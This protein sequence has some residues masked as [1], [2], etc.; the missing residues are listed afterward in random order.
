MNFVFRVDASDSIGSGHVMRCLSLA[1]ELEKR[2]NSIRFI[3]CN[4]D[5]NL[6]A[7]I[8]RKGYEVHEIPS[9]KLPLVDSH[10]SEESR[11]IEINN[12]ALLTKK[13]IENTKVDWLI[14]DHY[15]LDYKWELKLKKHVEAVLVIDD[16][17][18]RKHDCNILLDQNWFGLETGNRYAQLINKECVTL[19]GPNFAILSKDYINARK[20]LKEHS[21]VI[22]RILI[23]MGAVD[24]KRQTI[25]ALQALCNED[26]RYLSVDVVIGGAN[27]DKNQIINITSSRKKTVIYNSLPTLSELMM[28]ADLILCSGGATTWE[29]CC[30]GLPAIVFIAAENQ[31]KFTKLLAKDNVHVLLE[32][33]NEIT[34]KD[35]FLRISR[36][37]KNTNKVKKM[38]QLSSQ[39]VDGRG[40]SRI[41]LNLY[42]FSMPIDI[43]KATEDD[44]K[45]LF[46]W[47][48]DPIVRKFSFHH[49]P[50]TND[51]HHK[52][53]S[54][55][56][57]D[58]DCL[59]L[60]GIDSKNIP[61]GQVR[62]DS[63]DEHDIIDISINSAARGFGFATILLKKS[64]KFWKS[65]GSN[66]PL[67][68]DVFK[69]NKASQKVFINS[70]FR[71]KDNDN[72]NANSNGVIRYILD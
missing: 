35:W 47:A 22:K 59:I 42:G 15:S 8:K 37:I 18:N 48:N 70:G 7:F 66:K 20:S 16:L 25:E 57:N 9:N 39:I 33:S 2:K 61:I 64:V 51:Q 5:G 14:V 63:L 12:D 52:W 36:L 71:E 6:N 28:K 21:G 43:R 17:A 34:H 58:P 19:L 27:K 41:L 31:K 67:I 49:K 62:I 1:D 30:L 60:L 50:I 38:S 24:S 29:R 55:K 13:A 11:N 3:C 4:Y 40:I 56:T 65:T 68:G 10:G 53:F 54:S 32:S 72:D 26:L 46:D 23:F 44:E 69:S 45:L